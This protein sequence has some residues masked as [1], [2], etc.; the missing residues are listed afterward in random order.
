MSF[1]GQEQE[2]PRRV[3]EGIT[4]AGFVQEVVVATSRLLHSQQLT[5]RDRGALESCRALLGRM[6]SADTEDEI[7][8]SAERHLAATS[9]VALLRRSRATHP[10]ESDDLGEIIKA[11]DQMLAGEPDDTSLENIGRLRETFLSLGEE[12]LASMTHSEPTQEQ[13]NSWTPL[14]G[15][16]L[17]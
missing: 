4:A 16:S 1:P 13:S 5:S 7:P 2:N 10:S 17:S 15:S 3:S 8:P 14:I 11:I 6:L 9:T 12:N